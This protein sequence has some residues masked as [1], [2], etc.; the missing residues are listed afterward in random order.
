MKRSSVSP[1]PK[2]KSKSLTKSASVGLVDFLNQQYPK[3]IP[4]AALT[5]ATKYFG[6]GKPL[7]KDDRI[8]KRLAGSDTEIATST[9]ID[10]LNSQEIHE[11]GKLMTD[12]A[13]RRVYQ[14]YAVEG[15][16]SFEFL[17]KMG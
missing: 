4:I 6:K 2:G 15:K 9:L 10:V 1:Q 13:V 5:A 17:M 11:R 14:S 3:K 12:E 7:K 16:L 8:I